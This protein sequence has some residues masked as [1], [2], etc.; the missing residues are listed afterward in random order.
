VLLR[1]NVLLR[2]K[3]AS[4]RPSVDAP[5]CLSLDATAVFARA[6]VDFNAVAD[7]DEGGH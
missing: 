2:D 6:R 5:A 1:E 4:A 3:G 7:L